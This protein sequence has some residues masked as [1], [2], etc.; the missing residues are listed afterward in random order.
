MSRYLKTIPLVLIIAS[1]ASAANQETKIKLSC[2]GVSQ[3]EAQRLLGKYC[4]SFKLVQKDEDYDLLLFKTD[5]G[6]LPYTYTVADP[7]DNDVVAVSKRSTLPGAVKD[8]CSA[9]HIRFG[10]DQN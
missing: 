6:S 5:D 7:E 4:Q 9:M 2:A 10:E 1:F 8:S 3:V